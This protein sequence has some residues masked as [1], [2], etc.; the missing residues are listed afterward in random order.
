MGNR[1][2]NGKPT[3]SIHALIRKVV[4]RSTRSDRRPIIN[5]ESALKMKLI[6]INTP[7]AKDR[8]AGAFSITIAMMTGVTDIAKKP[9][10]VNSGI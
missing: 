4:R 3:G 10:N 9:S 1:K 8:F 5:V 7:L 6:A 2:M